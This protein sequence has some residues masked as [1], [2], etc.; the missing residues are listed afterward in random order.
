MLLDW[1]HPITV[2]IVGLLISALF[3]LIG[4]T[5]AHAKTLERS[6]RDLHVHMVGVDGRNGIKSAV[7]QLV[8]SRRRDEA[9]ARLDRDTAIEARTEMRTRLNAMEESHRALA[10]RV[11][12]LEYQRGTGGPPRSSSL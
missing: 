4:R 10:K 5:M 9:Q 6:V 8:E 1:S 12:Q 3:A 11:A 7:N 2:T